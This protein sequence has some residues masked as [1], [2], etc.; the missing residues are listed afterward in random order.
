MSPCLA[1][2]MSRR[3]TWGEVAVWP[4]ESSRIGALK[5]DATVRFVGAAEL[6][7]V[8]VETHSLMA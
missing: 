3:Q 6:A 4:V 2:V 5:L 1:V 7:T 8:S